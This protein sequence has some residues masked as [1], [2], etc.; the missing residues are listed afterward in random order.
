MKKKTDR[1]Q[2]RID[3]A[4]KAAYQEALEESELDVTEHLTDK[5]KEFITY[6]ARKKKKKAAQL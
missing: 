3:P 6:T 4:L 1:I 2:I 5:I